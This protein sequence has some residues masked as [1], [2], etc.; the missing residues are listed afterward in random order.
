MGDDIDIIN[1]SIIR[2]AFQ[3]LNFYQITK[4]ARKDVIIV[5][6]HI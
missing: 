2:K 1:K 3:T 4:D 6:E 5:M